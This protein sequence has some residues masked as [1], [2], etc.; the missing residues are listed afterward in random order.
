MNS[1]YQ[2]GYRAGRIARQLGWRSEY[3]YYSIDSQNEYTRQYS[4]GYRAGW[5]S[6]RS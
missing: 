5:H 6:S 4:Q 1:A 2:D 3:V